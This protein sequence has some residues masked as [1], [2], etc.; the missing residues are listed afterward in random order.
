MAGILGY[1]SFKNSGNHLSE[2]RFETMLSALVHHPEEKRSKVNTGNTWIGWAGGRNEKT[3]KIC[4]KDNSVFCVIEGDLSILP[5]ARNSILKSNP[6]LTGTDS[7]FLLLPYLYNAFES[8]LPLKLT[9]N[10][11]IFCFDAVKQQMILFNGRFGMLPLFYYLD[12][13]FLV[14]SS[15]LEPIVKS[16]LIENKWDRLT[17]LEQI[18]FNYPVSDH[19]FIENVKTLPSGNM[20]CRNGSVVEPENYWSVNSLFGKKALKRKESM[21][22]VYSAFEDAIIRGI[23][24]TTPDK[25]KLGLSLTGGWDGRLVLSYLLKHKLNDRLLLYSFGAENSTDITIPA[26]I[27]NQLSIP[28]QQIVLNNKYIDEHFIENAH[29]TIMLSNGH[30]PFLRTHYLYSMKLLSERT[31][32]VFS[33][34]C[35]SNILKYGIIKPGTVINKNL[36][37]LIETNDRNAFAESLFVNYHQVISGLSTSMKGK[38]AERVSGIIK[39]ISEADSLSMGYYNLLLSTVERKF[40]GTEQN[41]YNDYVYNYSP[42]IDFNF[43]ETL[44][45]TIFWGANYPF[46]SNSLRLRKLSTDLYSEIIKRNSSFLWNFPTDREVSF[47]DLT[48]LRGKFKILKRKFLSHPLQQGKFHTQALEDIFAKEFKIEMNNKLNKEESAILVS[49]EYYKGSLINDFK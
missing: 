47:K 13:H 6:E 48:T 18:V 21:D 17:Q 11:N 44:S 10:F 30:R 27:S 22:A 16:G 3:S 8:S 20:I 4:S 24:S 40:F 37:T 23:P 31:G 29:D 39:T 45:Q 49:T 41:S 5:E 7:D 14:F 28:Y 2:S 42:F 12:K 36:L 38:F 34:N 9:G 35:G 32:F 19:S 33:G 26:K 15:K 25:P 43:L 46:N 1:I